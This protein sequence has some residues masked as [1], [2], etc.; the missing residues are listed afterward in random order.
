MSEV[1][2]TVTHHTAIFYLAVRHFNE[3]KMSSLPIKSSWTLK[4]QDLQHFTDNKSAE[5]HN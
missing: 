5:V 1:N 2:L 3:R 4:G